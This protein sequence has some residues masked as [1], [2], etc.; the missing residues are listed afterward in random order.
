MATT[1]K[2]FKPSAS[3]ANDLKA[4]LNDGVRGNDS[5]KGKPSIFERIKNSN[6]SISPEMEK[7]LAQAIEDGSLNKEIVDKYGQD[8]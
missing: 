1:G 6:G 2:P 8:L 5:G 4:K 3:S 7:E